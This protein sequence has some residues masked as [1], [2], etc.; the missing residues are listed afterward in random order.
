MQISLTSGNSIVNFK[1]H[2]LDFTTLANAV[3]EKIWSPIIYKDGYRRG[4]NFLSSEIIALDFDTGVSIDYMTKFVEESDV[5][6]IVATTK[7]HQVAKGDKPPCDRFRVILMAEKCTNI[8]D[9]K[10]TLSYYI[11]QFG[12][13][14]AAKDGARFFYP[15]KKIYAVSL[16]GELIEWKKAKPKQK[17]K[18]NDLTDYARMLISPR[19]RKLLTEKYNDG[20][21]NIAVYKLSAELARCGVKYEEVLSELK[22]NASLASLPDEEFNRTAKNGWTA[23]R[24][25]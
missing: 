11:K 17:I 9:Y 18:P 6:G 23:G 21:R 16:N 19:T 22:S 8:D 2:D 15:C 4:D 5:C 10:E 25:H 3:C 24:Q 12:A 13:D 14:K 20:E 1:T 7:S